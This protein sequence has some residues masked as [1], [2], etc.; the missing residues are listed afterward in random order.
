MRKRKPSREKWVN[1]AELTVHE[2]PT[3]AARKA[4]SSFPRQSAR[5]QGQARDSWREVGT[6]GLDLLG[7]A[8]WGVRSEHVGSPKMCLPVVYRPASSS[9]VTPREAHAHTRMSASA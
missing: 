4:A 6:R 5:P 7:A 8:S 2:G 9:R 3:A 1:D